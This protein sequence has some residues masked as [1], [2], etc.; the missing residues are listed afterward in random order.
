M[1]AFAGTK[2]ILDWFHDACLFPFVSRA[3]LGTARNGFWDAWEP[4]RDF[5]LPHLIPGLRTVVTGHS[6][7]AWLAK[8]TAF[9]LKEREGFNITMVETF[10]EPAAYGRDGFDLYTASGIPSLAWKNGFDPVFDRPYSSGYI[11][12]EKAGIRD[13]VILPAPTGEAVGFLHPIQ[14][15]PN[16][17]LE[18]RFGYIRQFERASK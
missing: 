11:A 18:G 9:W 3:H 10:G 6:L 14:R 1:I 4:V 7:G 15:W 17:M 2:N 8:P 16:H 12:G 13:G 5:L